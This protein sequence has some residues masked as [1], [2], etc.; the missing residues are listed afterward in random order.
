MV[1]ISHKNFDFFAKQTDESL[2][3]MQLIG[4]RAD[5]LIHTQFGI[6]IS[7]IC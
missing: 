5:T 2:N 1:Q 7:K 6:K 4:I 3:H